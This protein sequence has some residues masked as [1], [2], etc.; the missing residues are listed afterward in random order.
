MSKIKANKN[1]LLL[2]LTIV[3]FTFNGFSQA[4]I[5]TDNGMLFINNGEDK[6]FIF[7]ITGKEVKTLK[8]ETPMFS[9]DGTILQILIV[10]LSNFSDDKKKLTDGE[11]LETHKIWESDYLAKEMYGKKLTL[12]SEK[13]TL[14][15]RN[16]LFWGFTRPSYNQQFARDYFLTTVIGKNL[17]GLGSPMKESENKADVKKMMVE[18]VKTLRVSDKEFD[19]EKIADEIKNGTYKKPS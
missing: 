7:E 17:L 9:V 6:S 13:L 1:V 12:D 5:K 11:L 2:L 18:M 4:V 15:T 3:L 14:D 16:F 19:V 8:S 10:P